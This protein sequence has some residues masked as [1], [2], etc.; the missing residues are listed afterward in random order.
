MNW[1]TYVESDTNLTTRQEIYIHEEQQ[2]KK[3]I[4]YREFEKVV[5]DYCILSHLEYL[6]GFTLLFREVNRDQNGILKEREFREMIHRID[7]EGELNLN[8]EQL[9]IHVDPFTSDQISYSSCVTILS[10][11]FVDEKNQLTLIHSLNT[12][13]A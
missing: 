6:R 1:V 7:P 5:L 11:I 3:K 2:R 8:I 10:N 13:T 12:R 9:L 4:K